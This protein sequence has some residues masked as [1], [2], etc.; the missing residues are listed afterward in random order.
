MLE[1]LVG[2]QPAQLARTGDED[3]FQA[4]A[5]APAPLEQFPHHRPRREREQHVHHEEHRPHEL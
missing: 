4:D 3:A 1:D 5:C 2:H